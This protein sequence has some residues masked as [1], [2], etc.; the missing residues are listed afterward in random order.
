MT[1]LAI[2]DYVLCAKQLCLCHGTSPTMALS[3]AFPARLLQLPNN[4][5]QLWSNLFSDAKS[6]DT[7]I[8]LIAGGQEG[9]AEMTAKRNCI[10]VILKVELRLMCWMARNQTDHLIRAAVWRLW[11]HKTAGIYHI[12][13]Y[14][15]QRG[16]WIFFR[17][18]WAPGHLLLRLLSQ[19]DWDQQRYAYGNFYSIIVGCLQVSCQ[20]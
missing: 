4:S 7:L 3:T 8:M 5:R 1:L 11:Q 2:N 14:A 17:Q 18:P 12:P 19:K 13:Q 16:A 15:K 10:S 20:W 9:A 6:H